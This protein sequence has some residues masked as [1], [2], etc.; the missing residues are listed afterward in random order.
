MFANLTKEKMFFVEHLSL[1]LRGGVS[2]SEA[3]SILKKELRSG[4]FKKAIDDVYQKVL[5]G[6]RLAK[7]LESHPKIF[8]NFFCGI[9]RVGEE[10]GTLEENLKYLSSQLR[11]EFEMKKKIKGALIYPSLVVSLAIIIAFFVSFFVL[12]KVIGLFQFLEI[13]LPL[14]TQIL[15]TSTYFFKKYWFFLISLILF[16][17]FFLRAFLILRP[18]RFYFDKIIFFLPFLSPIFSHLNLARFARTLQ[19]L[20]KSGVPV[21]EALEICIV[22]IPNEFYKRNLTDIKLGLERGEKISDGLKK[23]PRLFPS[24]FS[25][26]V[27]VGENAGSLEESLLELAEFHEREFDSFLKSLTAILEPMMLIL[28]GFFVAF[29]VFAIIT[30]IYQFTGELRFR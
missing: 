17:T 5:A 6:E 18:V 12:P 24:T 14:A 1:M 4:N 15:I 23:I 7:G 9:V 21:L 11:E 19:I 29:V 3:L 27:A 2:I 30:P 8:N 13:K 22:T 20:L 16:L 10:S 26:M 28:V 25:Q